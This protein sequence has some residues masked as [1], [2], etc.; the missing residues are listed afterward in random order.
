MMVARIVPAAPAD[1]RQVFV[2]HGWRG[3]ERY[4]G[5]RTDVVMRWI[6]EC[7]G[8]DAL[9]AERRAFRKAQFDQAKLSVEQARLNRG[10]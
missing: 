8:I 6:E 9:Q 7:G 5:A 10:G 1:F 2:Q 4:F 3:I